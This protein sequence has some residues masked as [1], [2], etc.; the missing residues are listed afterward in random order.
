MND[1][2]QPNPE[3]ESLKT[4]SPRRGGA[5][6]AHVVVVVVAFVRAVVL[7]TT[8]GVSPKEEMTSGTT[9]RSASYEGRRP[10]R[11]FGDRHRSAAFSAAAI[12]VAD[13]RDCKTTLS[14]F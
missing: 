9:S 13:P 10:S 7:A 14:G 4:R 6:N 11:R 8:P 5:F 12:P 2:I 1:L 3:S